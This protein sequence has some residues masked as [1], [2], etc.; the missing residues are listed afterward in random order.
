MQRRG[1]RARRRRRRRAWDRDGRGSATESGARRAWQRDGERDGRGGAR[2]RQ[3]RS[4]VRRVCGEGG[5]FAGCTSKLAVLGRGGAVVLFAF[6]RV[7]TLLSLRLLV[8]CRLQQR[9]VRNERPPRVQ[10]QQRRDAPIHVKR[11][12]LHLEEECKVRK[13]ERHHSLDVEN[14]EIDGGTSVFRASR[15]PATSDAPGLSVSD[16]AV[17]GVVVG[18]S[19]SVDARRGFGRV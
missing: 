19:L 18:C 17:A 16:S 7:V 8:L 10:P 11:R 14:L 1:L 4:G 3:R 12:V 2:I 15:G 9:K 5:V 6:T 13:V